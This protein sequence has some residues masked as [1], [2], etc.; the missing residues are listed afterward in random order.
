MRPSFVLY[1]LIRHEDRLDCLIASG[2]IESDDTTLRITPNGIH[3]LDEYLENKT[4]LDKAE[5][6]AR[7]AFIVSCVS[8][9][10]AAVSAITAVLALIS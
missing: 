8:T 3:K 2:Y 7:N 9:A 6:N 10:I 1:S 5:T 4:R